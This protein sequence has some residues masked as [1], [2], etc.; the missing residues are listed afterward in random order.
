MTTFTTH[1]FLI[2]SFA[3]VLA[4]SV[5][6]AAQGDKPV[7]AQRPFAS[8]GSLLNDV[9]S[10][11]ASLGAQQKSLKSNEAKIKADTAALKT[12]ESQVEKLRNNVK[13]AKQRV[14]P[15]NKRWLCNAFNTL[16]DMP[17][18][19]SDPGKGGVWVSVD[20]NGKTSRYVPPTKE[21]LDQVKAAEAQLAIEEAALSTKKAK[22]VQ[23]EK[24]FKAATDAYNTKADDVAKKTAALS[25]PKK[26]LQDVRVAYDDAALKAGKSDAE[27]TKALDKLD[28]L[29]GKYEG[30]PKKVSC[31]VLVQKFSGLGNARDTWKEGDS[32]KDK[33]LLPFKAAATFVNGKYESNPTGNHAVIVLDKTNDGL[34]VF[35]QYTGKP[36]GIRT[37]RYKGGLALDGGEAAAKNRANVG[38]G[39]KEAREAGLTPDTTDQAKREEYFQRKY[40]YYKPGNDADNYSYVK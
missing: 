4:A 20:A 27:V 18:Q 9:E 38:K 7:V 33:P 17:S 19:C 5:H 39:E 24:A 40:K 26:A 21:D 8:L 10:G 34:V 16:H 29:V 36:A 30:N 32:V 11:Y 14:S 31:V 6:V 1:R 35:D 15:D 3:I 25:D 23:D 12:A 37:I 2:L 28:N 22:L 13:A